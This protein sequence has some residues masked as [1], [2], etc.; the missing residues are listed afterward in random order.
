MIGYIIFSL[1]M[2]SLVFSF[3]NGTT[4]QVCL[5]V[6]EGADNALKLSLSLCAVMGLWGGIMRIAQKSGFTAL[7]AKLLSPIV[8]FIFKGI[9]RGGEA[10]N[11]IVMNITAN[12]LGLGNAATPLGLQAVKALEKESVN[13]NRNISLLVVINTASIQ[14]IPST[15]AAIRLSHGS[16]HPYEIIPAVLLSSLVS[17]TVGVILAKLMYSR[18]DNV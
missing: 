1:M 12:L 15:V 5:S 6:S 3:F 16:A 7:V 9:K 8:L 10:Y 11:A 4:E 13:R 2:F 18:G 17:V 14:L